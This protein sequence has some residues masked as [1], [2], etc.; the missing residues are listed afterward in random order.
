MARDKLITIRIEG[1]KRQAFGDLAKSQNT[2]TASLLYDFISGC[3]SGEIDIKLVTGK[4]NRIDN[5]LDKIDSDRID[6]LEATTQRLDNRLDTIAKKLND[7]IEAIDDRL[8]DSDQGLSKKITSLEHRLNA[9]AIQLDSQ[10]I[11]RIDTDSQQIDDM[12]PLLKR[13]KEC[14]IAAPIPTGETS[15]GSSDRP[16]IGTLTPEVSPSPLGTDA[17]GTVGMT[18]M[19]AA[20]YLKTKKVKVSYDS[21]HRWISREKTPD[22]PQGKAALKHLTLINKLYYPKID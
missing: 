18:A 9:L 13:E 8:T 19:D 16:A 3:L 4:G 6:K 2:D 1:E 7:W 11:D 20:K 12:E 21:L 10:E 5:Q 17:I 15:P 14:S 22:S